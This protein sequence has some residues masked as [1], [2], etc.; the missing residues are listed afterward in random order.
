M[1]N[2]S[3]KKEEK[4]VRKVQLEAIEERVVVKP[5]PKAEMSVNVPPISIPKPPKKRKEEQ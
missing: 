4:R 2:V 1:N 3:E 5:E